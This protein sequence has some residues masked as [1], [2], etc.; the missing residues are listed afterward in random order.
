M[1]FLFLKFFWKSFS[2][3]AKK[4]YTHVAFVCLFARCIRLF[5]SLELCQF[6]EA[7]YAYVN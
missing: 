7:Y 3:I 2:R 1:Q 4:I 6:S 5:L